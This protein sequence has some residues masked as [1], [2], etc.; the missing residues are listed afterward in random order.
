[1]G[2]NKLSSIAA[3]ALAGNFSAIEFTDGKVSPG[4]QKR[5]LEGMTKTLSGIA[6]TLSTDGEVKWTA[7][8]LNLMA[9]ALNIRNDDDNAYGVGEAAAEFGTAEGAEKLFNLIA[10]AK[11]TGRYAEY[12][13][14][15]QAWVQGEPGQ[16]ARAGLAGIAEAKALNTV[17]TTL[18]SWTEAQ[19]Q[20]ALE[21]LAG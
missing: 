15:L 11:P 12:A 18:E 19:R 14:A 9:A 10:E 3:L 5:S 7:N 8:E 17:A 6:E 13:E 21:I 1:M 2:T 16:Q 20:R 4:N